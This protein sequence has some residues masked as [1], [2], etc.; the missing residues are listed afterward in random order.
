MRSDDP[1]R[2][3][4]QD[5]HLGTMWREY[6][7]RVHAYALRHVDASVLGHPGS[8]GQYVVDGIAE[9]AFCRVC[10]ASFLGAMTLDLAATKRWLKVSEEYQLVV[11]Q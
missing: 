2:R 1:E 6:A 5:A 4:T 10:A 7:H 8:E 3:D 11:E 9:E